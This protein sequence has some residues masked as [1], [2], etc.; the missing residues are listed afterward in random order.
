MTNLTPGGTPASL[1]LVLCTRAKDLPGNLP[2]AGL[3]RDFVVLTEEGR[4]R[5]LPSHPAVRIAPRFEDLHACTEE[6][7]SLMGTYPIGGVWAPFER[8]V[9]LGGHLRDMMGWAGPGSEV[10]A[11]F[12]DKVLMKQR[13]R[14]AGLPTADFVVLEDLVRLPDQLRDLNWPVV[15]KPARGGGAVD[16]HRVDNLPALDGLLE[17]GVLDSLQQRGPVVAETFIAMDAEYHVDAIVSGG[18]VVFS[19]ASRYF[20]PLLEG[21]S[22]LNGSFFLSRQD[23]VSSRLNSMMEKVVSAF[24]F[25]DGV[26]HLEAFETGSTLLFSEVAARLPGGGIPDAIKLQYEVD[27][28]KAAARAARCLPVMVNSREPARMLANLHIPHPTGRVTHIASRREVEAHVSDLLR[29][30]VYTTVGAVHQGPGDSSAAAAM[31]YF[32]A[33]SAAGLIA[34]AEQLHAMGVVR[35]ACT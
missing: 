6:V 35:G 15:L 11:R 29:L 12:T 30:D 10:C 24:E 14:Q 21:P 22:A 31:A 8:S 9:Q 25:S 19:A 17:R 2:P 1:L 4:T 27:L 18:L 16:V 7:R 13:A 33:P 34:A 26:V 23:G 5:P 28:W 3:G 32:T 20:T